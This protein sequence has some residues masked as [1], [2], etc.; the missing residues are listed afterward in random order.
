MDFTSGQQ[1]AAADASAMP[2]F[3]EKASS[4]E[5]KKDQVCFFTVF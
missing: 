3:P 4:Q 5:P 1:Q 2:P